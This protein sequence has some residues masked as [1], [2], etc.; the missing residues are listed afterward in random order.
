[1]DSPTSR[2][3][4]VHVAAAGPLLASITHEKAQSTTAVENESTNSLGLIHTITPLFAPAVLALTLRTTNV[5]IG[6]GCT[7]R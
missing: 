5:L 6:I 1:L 7:T 2:E 4:S 3:K